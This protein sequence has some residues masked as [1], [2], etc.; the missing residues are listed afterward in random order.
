M[1]RARLHRVLR[2]VGAALAL[3]TAASP[4]IGSLHEASVRHVACP[5]DGE[6]IEAAAQAPHEHAPASIGA[7]A[8]FAER[9]PAD[10][11]GSGRTHEHCAI[12]AQAQLRARP[13]TRPVFAVTASPALNAAPS[14]GDAPRFRSLTLY[15]LAP[16]ASPPLA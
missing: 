4:V 6:L 2:G 11:G 10:A 1:I 8:I 13:Q 16:K 7:P 3:L 12:L 15:R 5:E 14:P 9:D